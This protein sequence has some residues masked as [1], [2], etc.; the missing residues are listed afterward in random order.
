MINKSE[1]VGMCILDLSKVLMYEFHYDYIKNKYGDISRLLFTGSDSLIYEIKTEVV[2]ENFSKDKKMFD[3]SNYSAKSKYYDYLNKLVVGKIKNETG[4]VAIEGFLGFKMYLVLVDDSNE[5]KKAKG[6]K[7]NT[8]ATI[9][10]NEYKDVL[11]N[12]KRC[13]TFG[14]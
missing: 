12:K 1:Y 14:E 8:V 9:S 4:D 3:P 2:S 11:L 5:Q 10:H 13:E 7:R 6:L